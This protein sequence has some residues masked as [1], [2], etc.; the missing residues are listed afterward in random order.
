MGSHYSCVWCGAALPPYHAGTSSFVDFC[1]RRCL[2]ESGAPSSQIA[3]W[4]RLQAEHHIAQAAART[5][6]HP[7]TVPVTK[8]TVRTS[9]R[10]TSTPAVKKK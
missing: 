1:S 9:V 6:G 8:P 2:I 7:P 3:A 4:E 10:V 5:V